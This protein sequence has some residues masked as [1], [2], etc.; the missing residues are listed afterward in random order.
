MAKKKAN[1]GRRVVS[2][3]ADSSQD[4]SGP[5]SAD[6]KSELDFY[7][8]KRAQ[9]VDI[10]SEMESIF[11]L[12]QSQ[13]REVDQ[14]YGIEKKM[15]DNMGYMANQ[16]KLVALQKQATRDLSLEESNILKSTVS[17]YETYN[18]E[19]ASV[20]KRSRELL[21][22]RKATVPFE[23]KIKSIQAEVSAMQ[24]TGIKNLNTQEKQRL[25][26]L[27][28]MEKGY[29]ALSKQEQ[30]NE[31]IEKAQGNINE[32]MDG[33]NSAAGKIFQT[34]K[35]I[36][37]NP[38]SLFVGILAVGLQR[39]ETMRQRGNELAEEMDRV[40]KKLAG[41][42]PFQDKILQK[43]ELIK[44]RFYEM[45]EG[46]SSSL[47]GSVD[48]IVALESQF[49][50]IDYVSGKLV[51]T[52]AEL[53]LSIG[54]SDEESAKVL[55]NFSIVGGMTD[56]AAINMTKMT[57]QMSEQAGLNPQVIFQDIASASGD[58]LASFSGSAD[59]LAKSAVTARRL[60]LTLDD[61]TKV[62]SS[63]LDFETS[64]EKEM[65]AQ[66]ITGMDLNFQKARMLAMQGDE[67][68]AMEE[69]MRQVGGLDKFNKMAPHQQR[70][71]AE[72]VGLTVGQ[73]QKSTAQRQREAAFAKTKQDLVQKQFDLAEKALPMLGKLDVG[74]GVM[75]RIAK[76][77]GD[78][79]MDVFGV[80]LKEL[81]A[82]FFKFLESPAFKTGFTNLLYTIKGV[83]VGIKDAVMGTAAFIDKLSG[84]A[85]G[86]FLKSFAS[87]DFSGSYG[88]A[89]G[90]GNSIGKGIAVLLGAKMLL[91]ATPFTPMFVS[92]GGKFGSMFGGLK[93]LLSGPLTKGGLPDKR[94]A[95]NKYGG[96]VMQNLGSKM[97]GGARGPAG[98]SGM[99]SSAGAALGG[100]AVG[101]AIVGKSI[102]DVATLKRNA[103]GKE[104]GAA[105][106]KMVGASLGAAIGTA[107]LPGIGTAVGAGIGYL[108]GYLAA[109]TGIFDDKLDTA[110]KNL[111][112]QQTKFDKMQQI[113]QN[114]MMITER[115]HHGMIKNSFLKLSGGTDD[116]SK[117]GLAKFKDKVLQAGY[118]TEKQW[119]DA[120][121]GGATAQDL[122]NLAT[123]GATT[124]LQD[125]ATEKQKEIDRLSADAGIQG[126][127]ADIDMKTLTMESIGGISKDDIRAIVAEQGSISTNA[128]TNQ[129]DA[130]KDG[131]KEEYIKI[132]QDL[133]KQNTGL[134]VEVGKIEAAL[135]IASKKESVY[136]TGQQKTSDIIED[137][138]GSL[139][140]TMETDITQ[141]A[142]TN[143]KLQNEILQTVHKKSDITTALGDGIDGSKVVKVADVSLKNEVQK[144]NQK[145]AG[146][147]LAG[148]GITYGPSHANGGIPTR[149]GELEGGEAV[150][151]KR[152]TAMFAGELSRI[153][154]AGGGVSFAKGGVLTQAQLQDGQDPQAT[155]F[156]NDSA[157]Y[158]VTDA[159]REFQR[160]R[161][162]AKGMSKEDVGSFLSHIENN[163][164]QD[165]TLGDD[166]ADN[167]IDSV[168]K[169]V[170]KLALKGLRVPPA[171]AEA[172][173]S[174]GYYGGKGAYKGGGW[175]DALPGIMKGV[176]VEAGTKGLM[177]FLGSAGTAAKVGS[178]L[179]L[180]AMFSSMSA[181]T[182]DT[183]GGIRANAIG[184][185]PMG[186]YNRAYDRS[187]GF[188]GFPGEAD[189][190][191][192]GFG[193][194]TGYSDWGSWSGDKE[195]F[196]HL[197]PG[198][199]MD[200]LG[201]Y[202][203]P[204]LYKQN[205][206]TPKYI[207]PPD[208]NF[209]N[210]YYP[211]LTGTNQRSSRKQGYKGPPFKTESKD[212]K[213]QKGMGWTSKDPRTAAFEKFGGL[214]HDIEQFSDG[215]DPSKFNVSM[216]Q[217]NN[218]ISMNKF[219]QNLPK[220][221]FADGGVT[222][223]SPI[224]KVNDMILT[225]DGQM[226]ETHED[227]NL[228]AKK[229]GITQKP[230][231]GGKSRV[232]ELLMELIM[233]S[234][235]KGDVY[236]DGAKVSAAVNQ[237]NYNA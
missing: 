102:Y 178:S 46:F 22:Y 222:P 174:P 237:S 113:E 116:L 40:N 106:S 195:G 149:Y 85:I 89:E 176:A 167:A 161:S 6:M 224:T 124:K 73:L 4:Y 118:V 135:K 63:L 57:Y 17:D 27:Q 83:I 220:R 78:L 123:H 103:S 202:S 148:G 42:G 25:A 203:D 125:F 214:H 213:F 212:Y 90:V 228:I 72:A 235:Q 217:L 111:V 150:I 152:S 209:A 226:I 165:S 137:V 81:E 186:M 201:I 126:R 36:V 194:Q 175:Q 129:G 177:N 170:L 136:F 205:T 82:T 28:T 185:G 131:R 109:E 2:P 196:G 7:G 39:F 98:V 54:L 10:S 96:G 100:F 33:Q 157:Y 104:T 74:L 181:G 60:G 120:V 215:G 107:I 77:I 191:G 20:A 34:L 70:A 189:L 44:K 51:K 55:D 21:D 138:L 29:K 218:Q 221:K 151:N 122:L 105:N 162:A 156:A 26:S 49:G 68:G 91:G 12:Q 145:A 210:E 5:S 169:T 192:F 159:H 164:S 99:S 142:V 147:I 232:E 198:D 231:S 183:K 45:G 207:G 66:L 233:V 172:L 76:V 204:K 114:K 206:K 23:A 140:K 216:K 110:R 59:E 94:F 80:G 158:N 180:S 30:I 3:L 58:T 24:I 117:E 223:K 35:D 166:L 193:E 171:A 101:G 211:R 93:K 234:K 62:S 154:Q 75:E 53:K 43:A 19:A 146:G 139:E 168:L 18:Q 86:S 155:N 115:K 84:G 112:E 97:F 108:G 61:M 132:V 182:L 143:K 95:A 69:V 87:K 130:L 128:F 38:L 16:V 65:E 14:M 153:N 184:K 41:A 230:S 188:K 173:A 8:K 32:L 56:E 31:R 37:T 227:D 134:D 225:K 160:H 179:F 163:E 92:M 50:K 71:L 141:M 64:I 187:K 200:V 133:I 47:E 236:M 199:V 79:F 88:Q 13:R 127:Q 197:T 119:T 11:S 229:G 190:G 48:A 121:S 208:L 144:N 67:A 219:A 52:M 15:L 9:L 1:Q